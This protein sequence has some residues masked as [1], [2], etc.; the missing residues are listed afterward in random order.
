MYGTPSI[1]MKA[2]HN[3]FSGTVSYFISKYK[4]LIQRTRGTFG[5]L[6]FLDLNNNGIQ[7]EGESVE[8]YII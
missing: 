3:K 7:D 2:Q 1:G 6:S 4:D 8:V 5:N